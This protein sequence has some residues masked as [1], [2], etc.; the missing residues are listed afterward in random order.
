MVWRICQ[1]AI[2]PADH[3]AGQSSAGALLLGDDGDQLGQEC[4]GWRL[5]RLLLNLFEELLHDSP[6]LHDRALALLDA[7]INSRASVP[8]VNSAS[9]SSGNWIRCPEDPTIIAFLT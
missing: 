5:S 3:V 2:R 4:G 1:Q 9:A 8:G 6:E 7:G